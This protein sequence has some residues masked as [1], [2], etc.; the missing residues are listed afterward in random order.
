MLLILIIVRGKLG[1]FE[2]KLMDVFC[3][4]Y[5]NE[6]CCLHILVCFCSSTDAYISPIYAVLFKLCK[7]FLTHIYLA[8]EL[9]S[10][11]SCEV[12]LES[13]PH[14]TCSIYPNNSKCEEVFNAQYKHSAKTTECN[15]KN[16]LF[17]ETGLLQAVASQNPNTLLQKN[18]VTGGHP[19]VEDELRAPL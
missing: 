11:A 7:K 5:F 17:L 2:L 14:F 6:S 4:E 10:L 1:L 12:S 16:I 18:A 15:D 3:V 8:E 9:Q 13:T 19:L